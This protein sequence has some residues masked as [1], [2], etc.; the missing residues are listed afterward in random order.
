VFIKHTG[1]E[2]HSDHSV[3]QQQAFMFVSQYLISSL[4]HHHFICPIMQQYAHLREYD[5]RRA[6]Q[7]GPIRTLTAALKRSIKTVTGCIFYHTSKK[8]YK[9][10]KLDK[11]IFSMLFLKTF[12]DAKFVVDG[13]AFQTFIT[14]SMKNFF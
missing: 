2:Q 4:H 7:Q 11:T 6:G 13:N 9:R 1:L 12:K 3:L 8:Y 10:E 5:S 14:L